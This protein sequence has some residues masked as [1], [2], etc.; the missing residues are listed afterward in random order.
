MFG[1][2]FGRS[3]TVRSY[4]EALRRFK[5]NVTV[6]VVELSLDLL[7]LSSPDK[8]PSQLALV[9]LMRDTKVHGKQHDD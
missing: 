1:A 5:L 8:P 3:E 2:A 7:I 6:A 4:A 9:S